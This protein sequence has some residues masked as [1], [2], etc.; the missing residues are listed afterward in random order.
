M[1]APPFPLPSRP[2][3]PATLHWTRSRL[4]LSLK[5]RCM[6]SVNATKFHRKSGGEQPTCPGVPWRDLQFCGPF[7]EMFFDRAQHGAEGIGRVPH[8]NP[9]LL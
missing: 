7:L 6:R 8:Y 2:G 1:E 3:F 9:L 5:E 4:R